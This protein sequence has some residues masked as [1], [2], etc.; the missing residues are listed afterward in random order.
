MADDNIVTNKHGFSLPS[1]S[2]NSLSFQY[3]DFDVG[4]QV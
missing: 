4:F 3:H 2:L 1:L